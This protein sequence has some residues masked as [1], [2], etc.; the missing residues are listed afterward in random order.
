MAGRSKWKRSSIK[1][2]QNQVPIEYHQPWDQVQS[3]ALAW[4]HFI[5]GLGLK[6]QHWAY[7]PYVIGASEA[8]SL[9][10]YDGKDVPVVPSRNWL[11]D[12]NGLYQ[13][14]G[15]VYVIFS[16]N[17]KSLSMMPA[18]YYPNSMA[19]VTINRHYINSDRIV[20]LSEFDK[21]VP[22]VEEDPLEYASVNWEKVQHNPTGYDRLMF[23]AVKVDALIDAAGIEYRQGLDFVLEDGFIKWLSSGRRPGFDN[24]SGLGA[25]YAIRYRYIPSFYIK[26]AAHELRSHATIDPETGA[27]KPVRGPMAAAIQI[28]WVFLQSLS[29]EAQSMDSAYLAPDGGNTGPR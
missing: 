10:H 17:S 25:V 2:D 26:Y 19:F 24:L 18:G 5:A 28:D 27:S 1:T 3:D 11:Y 23:K 16:S 7:M 8:G 4:N 29:E 12:N 15:D 6:M 22:I 13:Y 21:L 20:A 14:Q 9:R